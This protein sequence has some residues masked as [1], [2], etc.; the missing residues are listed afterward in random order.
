MPENVPYRARLLVDSFQ[1]RP[2]PTYRRGIKYKPCVSIALREWMPKRLI[3]TINAFLS[4][5][6]VIRLS[7][8]D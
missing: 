6:P 7:I 8:L 3:S 5:V 2:W 1:A 4:E